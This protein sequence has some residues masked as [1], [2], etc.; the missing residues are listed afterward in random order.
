MML[1]AAEWPQTKF[2]NFP[3]KLSIPD[4]LTFE[5]MLN[6]STYRKC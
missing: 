1:D 5:A 4:Y 6:T 3:I 2:D